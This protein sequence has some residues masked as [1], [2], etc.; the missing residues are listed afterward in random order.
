MTSEFIE[1]L[2]WEKD[3]YWN[4]RL[5]YSIGESCI[6]EHRGD[7][8]IIVTT[9]GQFVYANL[10]EEELVKYTEIIKTVEDIKS[11]PDK[12]TY[13]EALDSFAAKAAFIT[14]I[15]KI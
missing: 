1:S 5:I 10:T 9:T 7:V 8:G 11:H 4:N 12:Y 6:F 14:K 13:K 2:G 3:D 15:Q